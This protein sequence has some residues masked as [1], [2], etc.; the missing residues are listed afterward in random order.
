MIAN[1]DRQKIYLSKILMIL[2]YI[3]KLNFKD[4]DGLAAGVTI[5]EIILKLNAILDK[6]K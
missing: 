4:Y 5:D 2:K 6:S 1:N 3:R